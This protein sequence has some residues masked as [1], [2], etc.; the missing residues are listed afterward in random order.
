M[1]IYEFSW[2]AADGTGK[3]IKIYGKAWQPD[4]T[5]RAVILL[6]HGLGE[7]I[8]RYGHVANFFVSK[9]I[10]FMGNDRRGHGKS[11]GKKGH[12][13][14]MVYFL[15]EIDQ[16]IEE[17]KT[18]YPNVP[19]FLYG[20]SMGGNLVLNY[21]LRKKDIAVKGV[22]A[23]GSAIRLAFE[24][25]KIMVA[26]GKIARRI[27]PDFTQSNQLEVNHISR[28]KTVVQNYINDPLVHDKLTSETGLG[29]LEWGEW[30]RNNAALATAQVPTLIMHG[31]SDKLTSATG[32]REF[33]ERLK[34]DVT[35][36]EWN[37]LYHEIH[38]EPEQEQ[39]F[40]YTLDWL[41]KY[42]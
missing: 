18:R 5:P 36:K 22:I 11:E 38:N 21:L 33:A 4:T 13:K 23:T 26:I 15:Y 25:S 7:H 24:P 3:N 14:S 34:G 42:I 30:L 40:K 29:L 32:S 10:A 20:H 28:D 6:V 37:G 27:K 17:A 16:L 1:Q 8:S 19:I 9:G 12:T 31:G 2:N 41:N 39:V 35:Y